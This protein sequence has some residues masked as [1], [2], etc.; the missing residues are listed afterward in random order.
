VKFRHGDIVV[1]Y[2]TENL[3][4]IASVAEVGTRVALTVKISSAIARRPIVVRR[5][6]SLAVL[7]TLDGE[8]APDRAAV[9]IPAGTVISAS[10]PTI[11]E[12]PFS[13]VAAGRTCRYVLVC[14]EGALQT[15]R[16]TEAT[17]ILSEG[18]NSFFVRAALNPDAP[19]AALSQAL[20]THVNSADSVENLA[21]AF[22]G[23][24]EDAGVWARIFAE[25]QLGAFG[26]LDDLIQKLKIDARLLAWLYEKFRGSTW[27][28]R[29]PSPNDFPVLLLPVRLETR[30]RGRELLIRVYPDQVFIDSH[31]LRLTAAEVADG[32]AFA[33]QSSAEEEDRRGAW[34]SLAQKY[35]PRRAAWIVEALRRSND[36]DLKP[37]SDGLFVFPKLTTLPDRFAA[38]L[39]R[40]HALVRGPILGNSITRPLNLIGSPSGDG[41]DLFDDDSRWVTD[42]ARALADGMAIRVTG[43]APED[44]ERGFTKVVVVGLRPGDQKAG[45]QALESL[46]TSHH[47]S[48]GLGFV[49]WGTP[50]N[51]TAQAKSGHSETTEDGA[52][53]Y[54]VEIAEP[55]PSEVLDVPRTNAQRLGCALGLG[56]TSS[57]LHHI[58]GCGSDEDS[59]AREMQ[60]ALWPGTGDYML[61]TLLA[62]VVSDDH[63]AQLGHH[64]VDHVRASG[65]LPCIRV[66]EQPYGVLP[67]AHFRGWRASDK[68]SSAASA[69]FDKAL[70]GVLLGLSAQWLSWARD[71][72]RVPRIGEADD[73]DKE[74]IEVLAME[75]VSLSHRIRPFVDERF[76]AWL[77]VAMR[78]YVF[79]DDTPYVGDSPL[80]WVKRWTD[81]WKKIRA[82]QAQRWRQWLGM[83]PNDPVASAFRKSFSESQ[84][85]KTTA[86]WN[87]RPLAEFDMGLVRY[88]PPPPETEPTNGNAAEAELPEF[89]LH[90]LCRSGGNASTDSHTLLR[91]ILQRSL[92]TAPAPHRSSSIAT[93]NAQQA[94]TA[95]IDKA[96]VQDAI[97]TLVSGS[98]VNFLNAVSTPSQIARRLSDRLGQGIARE[99]GERVLRM[100]EALPDRHYRTVEQVQAVV[101]GRRQW[102]E[103]LAAFR[104]ESALRVTERL[105]RESLDLCNNRLDAWVTSL[106][107][108]RLAAMRREQESGIHIGAYGY[109]ENL[110][111]D[112]GELLESYDK[113]ELYTT[114]D[115][116]FGNSLYD[117]RANYAFGSQCVGLNKHATTT[118]H[119]DVR[120][121]G[122]NH[123]LRAVNTISV[124][125][126]IPS[127][128]PLAQILRSAVGR[129]ATAQRLSVPGTM[130][131]RPTWAEAEV[132]ATPY[133][134]GLIGVEIHLGDPTLAN[135]HVFEFPASELANGDWNTLTFNVSAPDRKTGSGAPLDRIQTVLVRFAFASERTTA[136]GLLVDRMRAVAGSAG[137]IHAPSSR[138]AAAGAVLH[139][140]Y[141]THAN[142]AEVNPFRI[143]LSS[144][145][146][147]RA[148][149]ILEGLRQGQPLAALLGYQI[150]RNL[151]ERHQDEH[152]DTLRR[153]FPL[154]AAKQPRP[155]DDAATTELDDSQPS[156]EAM[157][158]RNVVDG[159]ALARW[160]DDPDRQDLAAGD[161]AAR[162]ELGV[163]RDSTA[164]N[165]AP[166]REEVERLRDS[167]DA[168]S[169]ALMYEGVYHA[170]QGNYERGSAAIEAISGQLYAPELESVKT[171]VSGRTLSQRLLLLFRSQT[172]SDSATPRARFEPRVAAWASDLF[173]ALDRIA[174]RYSFESPRIDINKADADRLATIPGV[175][176]TTA[177]SLV[178]YR[179]TNGPFETLEELVDPARLI[180]TATLDWVRRWTMTGRE[181]HAADRVYS[182]IDINNASPGELALLL[183]NDRDLANAI[184]T[185]QPLRR[186]AELVTR[187]GAEADT[188]DALRPFVET[189]ARVLRLDELG[190]DAVDLMYLSTSPVHAEET[191]VER[192][193]HCFVRDEYGLDQ[194]TRVSVDATRPTSDGFEYGLE[195]A[196]ELGRQMLDTLAA[197]TPLRPE[198]LC[199]SSY[200]ARAT[201]GTAAGE[202]TRISFIAADVARLDERIVAALL[203]ACDLASSLG[204]GPVSID[205]DG[206]DALF[207]PPTSASN[208]TTADVSE[209]DFASLIQARQY[210]LAHAL[211]TAETELGLLTTWLE[212]WV[213]TLP[214]NTD[215]ASTLSAASLFGVS[216][217]SVRCT[218]DSEVLQRGLETLIELLG[219][220]GACQ[221]LRSQA[222]QPTS[223][224]DGSITVPSP[225][226]QIA[227]LVDA[228]RALFGSRTVILPDFEP[229]DRDELTQ[230]VARADLGG[231]SERLRLW[232][233]Q[234]AQVHAPAKL[235]D[236]TM[237]MSEAWKAG[238]DAA[239]QPMIRLRVAQLPAS[240]AGAWLG[241]DDDERDSGD[242]SP[243]GVRNMLSLV[244][245]ANEDFGAEFPNLTAGLV[246]DQR[247]ETIP[248]SKVDTS[249]A[250]HYDG[251]SAQAPQA[252]LLAV[253]SD[254]KGAAWTRDELAAVVVD[255]MDLAKIRLVD[256][257]AM[258]RHAE[259]A[260]DKEGVGMVLPALMV[261]A[262]DESMALEA[263]RETIDDWFTALEK[264]ERSC[265]DGALSFPHVTTDDEVV[266]TIVGHARFPF[267][268]YARGLDS[269]LLAGARVQIR[270]YASDVSKRIFVVDY[271][272][273][274]Y[275]SGFT[276]LEEPLNG[277]VS[278]RG[279]SYNPVLLLEKDNG[280]VVA[281][282]GGPCSEFG[283]R[284]VSVE[285]H[286]HASNV[287][288]VDDYTLPKPENN[289][290][291][292]GKLSV[293]P[294]WVSVSYDPE[295]GESTGESGP[296]V[297]HLT[298]GNNS[299]VLDVT[300]STLTRLKPYSGGKI[301]VAG[302]VSA[303]NVID[304]TSWGGLRE[305]DA[306]INCPGP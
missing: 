116:T 184:A 147:R 245:A 82:E 257:D 29:P 75:P 62:G 290:T 143:N 170:V 180:D 109:V 68:D 15:P 90:E 108:K 306:T 113:A 241:L 122:R 151:H 101:G 41:P 220:V 5:P 120:R 195:E 61:R 96:M 214:A 237:D 16:R 163:A 301:V 252:L 42:F 196:L 276:R 303:N 69:T 282:A 102:W 215:V 30:F 27:I 218:R 243:E 293:Q 1:E 79:G 9:R 40:D 155:E 280:E 83:A 275:P 81:A 247:E 229:P 207:E 210:R 153:A 19:N 295:T 159:L 278:L 55:A 202:P 44:L 136:S 37:A 94:A 228:G 70:H 178:A 67:V 28:P 43:L 63:L 233:Q 145:R 78:D 99:L 98:M 45:Q 20:L 59:Y 23:V 64:F 140:A 129:A 104:N 111:P 123:D 258:G 239:A 206:L 298:E 224:A 209:K 100:R 225:G 283:G 287:L 24:P 267:K 71:P 25:R 268:N 164:T 297:A 32:R 213:A 53:S 152:I 222:L 242:E 174:C 154:V 92:S 118:L 211:A 212:Q 157:A 137:Y 49:P 12:L 115:R 162:A 193:I 158:A 167:M 291:H 4:R 133:F 135:A 240:Y 262:T 33:Q 217:A 156:I 39:Y 117:E 148:Q 14:R 128:V 18:I 230:S 50:T 221:A 74:L 134:I 86:W 234:L 238:I 269:A 105:F 171:L 88:E 103:L 146:V 126:Y 150:E 6:L 54:D 127:D 60:T 11:I 93:S 281:L 205:G 34:E 179:D 165:F 57:A 264:T 182:R 142:G 107:T 17:R 46:L 254:R 190:I 91:T 279:S 253:P 189:G 251:P 175:D 266:W 110:R 38:Y 181:T 271:A 300:A 277:R 73:P 56:A 176:L 125:V 265:I 130:T 80:V 2:N 201:A 203:E 198:N 256:A 144:A 274:E 216:S 260:P 77:L 227:L 272:V 231:G 244:M 219:R 160:W 188:V 294:E 139:N 131:A 26:T 183:P 52:T 292:Y 223:N 85:L 248:G 304:V 36:P 177:E 208:E 246:L 273:H 124:D 138:Q 288:W 13:E 235:L 192:R 65:P 186:L 261:P 194:S 285:G 72:Q 51:N 166:L 66:G 48:T 7:C 187:F 22:D 112:S 31:E 302:P 47:Y 289:I 249:I 89:Y 95:P 3:P 35:G 84:L 259:D 284:R 236:E 121:G 76:V 255:T 299:F 232:L 132:A 58:E 173:G 296:D 21:A 168:V 305:G 8:R 119:G 250:F 270:G 87:A 114:N 263:F 185:T 286:L 199:R 97:C 141:L 149:R 172:M 10:E 161:E 169:D 197:G 204:A 200:A 226:R 191:E 106:A